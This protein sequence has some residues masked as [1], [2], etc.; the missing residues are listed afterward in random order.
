MKEITI[1]YWGYYGRQEERKFQCSDRKIDMIMRAAQRIDLSEVSNCSKLEILN[2][3][4]NMLE[5]IDF[6]P[7]SQSQTITTLMLENNHLTSLDLWPLANCDSVTHLNLK[8][9][10]LPGLDLT[11]IFLRARIELDSSVVISADHILRFSLTSEQL[12]E[13]FLLLRPDR[14]PWTATPVII[15]NKYENLAKKMEWSIIYQRIQTVL[16]QISESDWYAVQR[17]FM[18]ALSLD[19][20]AGYDGDPRNLLDDTSEDMNYKTA[21]QSIIDRAI[22]LLDGQIER[23]GATL[24]LDTEAMKTTR[25]S[26]LIPKIVEAR[27]QEMEKAI[28]LTK[29]SVSIMNSL[30]LSYYGFKIMEAL[31]VGSTLH[32]GDGLSRMRE[33]FDELGFTLRTKEVESITSSQITDPIKASKSLKKHVLNL[34]ERAYSN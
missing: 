23:G 16:N 31:D 30:W 6:S 15:W 28:V 19:E 32:M 8:N 25:A 24:F 17:G 29:G 13:R 27:K 26:K 10:R 21:R 9:N 2:L 18:M 33:S 22:E 7:L 11:P 14:A 3:S 12:K 34:V 5:E 1:K 20:L 4:S